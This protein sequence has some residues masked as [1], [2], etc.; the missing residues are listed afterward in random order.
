MIRAFVYT[1]VGALLGAPIAFTA[2]LFWAGSQFLYWTVSGCILGAVI[3]LLLALYITTRG[4]LAGP[5]LDERGA[6]A[7]TNATRLNLRGLLPSSIADR[8]ANRLGDF[9]NSRAPNS[10]E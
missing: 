8:L 2:A 5:F 4:L 3:G 7:L 6:K 9:I 10:E 1:V